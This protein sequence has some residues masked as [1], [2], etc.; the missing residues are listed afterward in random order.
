MAI[1][2]LLAASGRAEGPH[3][4]VLSSLAQVF[5]AGAPR[6]DAVARLEAA[7]G[8]WEAFQIAVTAGKTPLK[9]V[10]ADIKGVKAT[11]YRVG[12][13]EVKEPSSVEGRRGPWPDPL[14]PD[15]DPYVGE[16]RSAFPFDVPAGESRAIWV[17]VWVPPETPA[18]LQR[19]RVSVRAD[20]FSVEVP[21]ELEVHRF[22]LPKSAS[23]PVTFGITGNALARAHHRPDGDNALLLRRYAVAALRHRISLHGGAME[24][25]PLVDGQ[26]DFTA[27]DAE[28]APFLDGK[29]DPGGAA[30]GARWTAIDLRVPWRMPPAAREAYVRQVIA[31]FRA[32]GWLDRLFAYT[33][34][35]PTDAQL[36]EVRERAA[37]LHRVAPEVPRLVTKEKSPKLEGAVDVWCPT[38]NYLDDKPSNSS[39]PPRSAYGDKLW[40]YQA[41]MSHGCDIVGG[42]YFA[43]WP[44]LAIDAPALSHRILEW[45]T[46]AYDVRGELYYNVVEAYVAGKDP[47]RDQRLHGGNGDGTLFYPGRPDVIGGKTDIPVESIRLRLVRDGLED[48]EY[49]RA[50]AARFGRAATAAMVKRVARQTYEWDKDPKTLLAVRREIA[51]ALD[52]KVAHR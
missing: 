21:V 24:P 1:T 49:L 32:R 2:G 20:G 18:G 23:L 43:G 4:G 3:V 30:E 9:N 22:T 29:A 19:G 28:I 8:E 16:K 13:V 40:W 34:D 33:W 10:R 17:D 39:P 52:G 45:L 50:H 42:S 44:N 48:Y 26:V 15:V 14:I 47:W 5:P 51:A 6:G 38:V 27:Y 7:R 36:P 46:F 25:P 37:W 35:E 41:C 11:L 31:H 12:L